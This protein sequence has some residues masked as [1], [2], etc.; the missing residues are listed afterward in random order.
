[1]TRFLRRSACLCTPAVTAITIFTSGAARGGVGAA[2][3][4]PQAQA[5]LRSAGSG[6]HELL[7]HD[8]CI[9][10]YPPQPDTCLHKQLVEK[11]FTF[12]GKRGAL[13][14][15]RLRVRGLFEPTTIEGGET[16][17]PSRSPTRSR[18]TG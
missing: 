6:F 11:S 10:D 5:D 9:G 2:Q 18:S 4:Q 17:Y 12:G 13:Y 15:V 3:T 14:D 7:L 8:P 16:P 1:M